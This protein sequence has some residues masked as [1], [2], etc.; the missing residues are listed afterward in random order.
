M[1]GVERPH[2]DESSNLF[3]AAEVFCFFFSSGRKPEMSRQKA[4]RATM[5]IRPR[6]EQEFGV[7]QRERKR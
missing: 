3:M 2:K 5:A 7:R 6:C 1:V 4:E